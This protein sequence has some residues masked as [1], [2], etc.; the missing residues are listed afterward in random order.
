LNTPHHP[1]R[2]GCHPRRS[3]GP[4]LPKLACEHDLLVRFRR[5]YEHIGVFDGPRTFRIAS[6]P[7]WPGA[8]RPPSAQRPRPL[9]SN[10]WKVA[11]VKPHPR[12]IVDG[13]VPHSQS[14]ALTLRVPSVAVPVYAICPALAPA[15]HLLRSVGRRP[16]ISQAGTSLQAKRCLVGRGRFECPAR[17]TVF[18]TTNRGAT[19][20]SSTQTANALL[21]CRELPAHRAGVG[22][23][24]ASVCVLRQNVRGVPPVPGGG[25]RFCKKQGGTRP[26]RW[27]PVE[28]V[29][30]FPVGTA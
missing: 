15:G 6:L 28:A 3:H 14:I 2:V 29:S 24:P 21:F 20:A 19:T 8:P 18:I 30:R 10:R 26:R 12:K 25:S 5:G 16:L 9:R 7:Q 13:P 17:R 1:D 4:G 11:G 27:A 23:I 22:A